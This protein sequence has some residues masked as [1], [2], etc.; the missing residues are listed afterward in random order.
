MKI[1]VT[2]GRGFLGAALIEKINAG[3][4]STAVSFDLEDG[5]DIM[6]PD[7]LDHLAGIDHVVHLAGM[8]GTAELFDEPARAINVNM[9]GTLNVLQACEKHG[10]GYTGITMPDSNWANVYQATKLGAM[11]LASAWHV[12]M[13][14]PVSHV[15]A[16]NAFGPRQKHGE[17][18]PQKILPTFATE[19]YAKRPLPVWGNG[20]QCV[21]L[22]HSDDV[23]EMLLRALRFGDDEVF[24]AGTGCAMTVRRVAEMVNTIAGNDRGIEYLPMRRGETPDTV[25]IARG[26]GWDKLGWKPEFDPE[27][28]REAVESYAPWH[29]E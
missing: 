27:K 25:I 28:F 26:E 11:K 3:D 16:F 24:D 2:G 17:G 20:L 6:D 5:Y 18:H 21:D 14:V 22:V 9:I 12:N 15:R 7:S 10:L 13:G 1:A 29:N 8:L 23:A 4:A 19:A